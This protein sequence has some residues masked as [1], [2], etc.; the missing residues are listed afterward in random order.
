MRTF[1]EAKV[2]A[3]ALKTALEGYKV[4]ISHS[5]ALEIVAKPMLEIALETK[6]A[7][8]KFFGLGLVENP[9]NRRRLCE[10]DC[11]SRRRLADF[12]RQHV[13]V[14]EAEFRGDNFERVAV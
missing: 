8:I 12:G 9:E 10:G 13:P 3:K 6:E 7:E 1:L 5:H 11:S 2:M 4:S 14:F